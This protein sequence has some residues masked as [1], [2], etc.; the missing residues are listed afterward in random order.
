MLQF[1]SISITNLDSLYRYLAFL[2]TPRA[3]SDVIWAI[4]V[5]I[6]GIQPIN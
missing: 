3:I 1:L 4:S 5:V 2:N 6:A